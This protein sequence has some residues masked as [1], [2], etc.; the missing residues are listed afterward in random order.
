MIIRAKE[1]KTSTTKN[2]K[3]IKSWRRPKEHLKRR[4][5]KKNWSGHTVDEVC[6]C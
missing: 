3:V 5:V 4:L 1:R 2:P 6:S